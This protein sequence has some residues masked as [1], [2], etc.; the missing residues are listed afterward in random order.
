M[1]DESA[2]EIP[3]A[4]FEFFEAM[5][6]QG[7]GSPEV[8]AALYDR[9][10]TLLPARPKAADMGC[11][12]GAAGLVLAE[13]GADVLGVDIHPPFLTAFLEQA[14]RKGLQAKVNTLQ[15][16]MMETDLMDSSLDLIWSEGAVFT[17]GFD[18]AFSEFKRLIKPGGLAVV[19]ECS[20]LK[21]DAPEDL[22]A[23][24][25]EGYP[26]MRTTLEN[27]NAIEAA[28]WNCLHKE[29]LEPHIWLN[30]FYD[31]MESLIETI[32]R[33]TDPEMASIV[34]EQIIEIDL[35]RRYHD[36]YGYVFYVAQKP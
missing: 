20:W 30:G 6:R 21:D 33:N 5:P 19:S 36:F 16:S 18:A 32:D 7:P 4:L 35:F 15:A 1:T 17:V 11:G 27:A 31:P 2:S 10:S 25:S 26:G 12:S 23:F 22:A 9:I 8:T 13:K 28:G 29:T 24:W 14:D 34:D 3:V